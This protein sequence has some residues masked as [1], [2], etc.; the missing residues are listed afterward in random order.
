MKTRYIYRDVPITAIESRRIRNEEI[1]NELREIEHRKQQIRDCEDYLA[2]LK[3]KPL[4]RVRTEQITLNPGDPGYD[5][6]P[7]QFVPADFQGDIR[8]INSITP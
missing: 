4:D 3:V 1:E 6:A 7:P 5:E 2:R 8:W